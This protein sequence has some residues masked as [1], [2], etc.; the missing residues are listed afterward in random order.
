MEA[1]LPHTW[2]GLSIDQYN[3]TID[4]DEHLDVY[5]TQV[6]LYTTDDG[7]MSLVFPTSLKGGAFNWFIP[8]QTCQRG[9]GQEGQ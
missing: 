2:K 4:F 8:L 3:D 9:G 5:L 6:S 1:Q 7:V